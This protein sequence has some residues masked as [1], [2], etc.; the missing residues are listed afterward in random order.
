MGRLPTRYSPVRHYSAVSHRASV[1][2]IDMEFALRIP[3]ILTSDV[4]WPTTKPFDLHVLSTPPAFV[5][6]Q[7]QTLLI[8]LYT[9]ATLALIIASAALV[10]SLK[11]RVLLILAMSSGFFLFEPS[12]HFMC[13]LFRTC[14]C[15]SV[16][17]RSFR[18]PLLGESFFFPGSLPAGFSCAFLG[19]CR[20]QDL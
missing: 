8:I 14:S 11:N 16:L 12:L 19:S 5:L 2:G 4:W 3:S 6:S 1:V 18:L 10:S 13:W 20:A 15:C 9:F 17:S 7:D